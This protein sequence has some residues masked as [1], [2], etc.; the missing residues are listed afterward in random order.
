[1][2]LAEEV[3]DG[4]SSVVSAVFSPF[5]TTARLAPSGT[6]WH[7]PSRG[8]KGDVAAA[9]PGLGRRRTCFAPFALPRPGPGPFAYATLPFTVKMAFVVHTKADSVFGGLSYPV[10]PPHPTPPPEGAFSH[11][12]G[13]ARA[14]RQLLR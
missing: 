4:R 14:Q 8:G 10:V 9:S 3:W 12:A 11:S 5:L 1:M 6:L 7:P 2:G 13:T